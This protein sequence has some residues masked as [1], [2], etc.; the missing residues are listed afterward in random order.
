[1]AKKKIHYAW[2]ILLAV[3][4]IRGFA[5]GGINTTS[6]LFLAP[7][8]EEIGIGVGML[9]I[10]LSITSIILV[11]FLPLA[12]KLIHRYDIRLLAVAGAFLQALSFAAFGF[13][14]NV[15]GWYLLAIPQAIG[16]ALIVNLLGPIMINRWFAKNTGLMLGIQMACVG[17]FGAVLQPVT[18]NIIAAD[19]WRSAYF[20]IGG[21]T[22]VVVSVT[23]VFLLRN[24]P[25]DSGLA[26]Y[27]SEARDGAQDGTSKK[28]EAAA[29]SGPA[30]ALQI[31]EK[32]AIKSISF[33][34]L[35]LFMIS[36]TG[37][38]VFTQHIPT[39]GRLIGFT[40]QQ[41]GW[42]L[43]FASIGNAVGSVAIGF[44]SDRI[45]GLKTCYGIIALGIAAV[46][47]FLIS[48][49][50]FWLFSAAALMHGLVSASIMVL[51]PLLTIVFYGQK[52]YE[53]IYS[54][55]AMGAPIASILLI[56]A[57]G[58][59]YDL[60]NNYVPVLIGMIALL[61]VAAVCIAAGWKNRCDEN[62]CPTWG[63]R[64]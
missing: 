22:F 58:F 17:L 27:G 57:Y 39:Y 61:L 46:V 50:S 21:L 4:L 16:A 60:M 45:G 59:V 8:S 52:D 19:G 32:T 18:A 28:E 35:L 30:P 37:V 42:A 9:S 26:A 64:S 38:G 43:S 24:T 48:P 3:I 53:K 56:P 6:G 14:N 23:A 1:M 29:K 40:A 54:K 34:L 20:L 12:G 44:I 55:V 41:T 25:K 36:L 7:V 11:F 62:G 15:Y 10:Y 5:G 33:Y 63:R 31:S 13:L 47:L 49:G 51:S 2:I